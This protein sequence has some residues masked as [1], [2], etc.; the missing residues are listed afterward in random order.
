MDKF[1]CGGMYFNLIAL[2]EPALQKTA[3]MQQDNE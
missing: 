3:K 1:I 2:L